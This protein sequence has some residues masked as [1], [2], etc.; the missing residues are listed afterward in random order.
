MNEPL[1]PQTA[2]PKNSR[3]AIWSLVLGILSLTCFGFLSG[4]PAVICGHNARSRIKRS[5]G[6]LCG[7]GLALAGL[8]TGYIAIGF[9]LLMLPLMLA[10]AIPNFVKA[11]D[12]A[13]R[14]ACIVNLRQLEAA[15]ET[16][17]LEQ[18]K[19]DTDTPTAKDL[20][21]SEEHTSELQSLRHLV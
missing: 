6:T 10:I 7:A 17:K 5:G 14:S 21:R 13:Q 16:W 11:R 20:Y 18:K 15:K 4:V 12:T 1:S 3:L 19:T 8:I 2:S 9:S